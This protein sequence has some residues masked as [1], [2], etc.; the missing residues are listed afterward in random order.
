MQPSWLRR[1]RHSIPAVLLLLGLIAAVVCVVNPWP[2]ALLIRAVFGHGAAYTVSEMTPYVPAGVDE[3]L[4]HERVGVAHHRPRM[5]LLVVLAGESFALHTGLEP[6]GQQAAVHRPRV[7]LL[8]EDR[9]HP[10]IFHD[11]AP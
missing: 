9:P 2:A 7:A 3:Q 6:V 1:P 5:A 10:H 8:E 11:R 4:E